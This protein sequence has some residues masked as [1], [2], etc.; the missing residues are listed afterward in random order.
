MRF[1]ARFNPVPFDS[2]KPLRNRNLCK[3][4]ARYTKFSTQLYSILRPEPHCDTSVP[5]LRSFLNTVLMTLFLILIILVL[6][7]GV[8]EPGLA[9]FSSVQFKALSKRDSTGSCVLASCD[10][11]TT[12][13]LPFL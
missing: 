10:L 7:H 1:T 4:L 5:R 2:Q 3:L 12:Y 9:Q 11:F 8:H 13:Q 6:A